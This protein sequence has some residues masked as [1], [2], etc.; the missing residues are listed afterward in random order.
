MKAMVV[1]LGALAEPVKGLWKTQPGGD[2][3]YGIVTI[4]ACGADICGVPGQGYDA[5]G[6]DIASPNIGR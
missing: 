3:A 1:P 5:R 6:Q 2:G 4:H